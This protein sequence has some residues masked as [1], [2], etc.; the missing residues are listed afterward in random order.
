M[1][2]VASL[3]SDRPP[4]ITPATA[5]ARSC[6]GNDQHLGIERAI[7]AVERLDALAGSCAANPN[8]AP[9]KLLEIK[10]VHGLAQLEQHVV[11]HVDNVVDRAHA[12]GLK[13]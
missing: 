5:C 11:G 6:V 12:A 9:R 2:F 1:V 10:R 3:T 7:G 8:C 13:S 4:P